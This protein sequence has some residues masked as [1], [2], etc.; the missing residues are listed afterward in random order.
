MRVH[1][2]PGAVVLALVSIFA[3][4]EDLEAQC[5]EA[6][7]WCYGYAEMKGM[8]TYPSCTYCHWEWNDTCEEW[9][10]LSCG[11]G[12]VDTEQPSVEEVTMELEGATSEEAL[13]FVAE[14]HSSH[15]L[16]YPS[17]NMVVVQGGCDGKGL[18]ALVFLDAWQVE[19]LERVGLRSLSEFMTDAVATRAEQVALGEASTAGR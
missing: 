18:A 15:L 3:A 17:R 11:G 7:G 19:T 14:T 6:C 12:L 13:E 2:L 5:F 8:S 10:C 16:V 1:Q 9:G 4:T